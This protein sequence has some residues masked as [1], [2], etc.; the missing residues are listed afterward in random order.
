MKK[1]I[2]VRRKWKIKPVTKVKE[3]AKAYMRS[4][5]KRLLAEEFRDDA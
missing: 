2:K 3:N 1:K 5:A 4:K